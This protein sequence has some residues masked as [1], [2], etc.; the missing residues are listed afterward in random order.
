[1]PVNRLK[2]ALGDG[3]TQIG[4]WSSLSSHI[5]AEIVAGAGFDWILIDTE[6]SPNEV[7]D[8]HRQLQAIQGSATSVVVRPPW[9][10]P[11]VIKRLLDVGVQ[12]LLVPFVQNADEARRAVAATRYPPGGIRGVATTTRANR[13]GRVQDYLGRA[14]DEICVIV[15]IETRAALAGLEAIAAVEGVDA[16]FIGPSDLAA[17]MGHL[18]NNGHPEV[19]AAMD[20]AIARIRATGK[21]AGILTPVEADARRWLDLGCNLMAV[22]SDAGILARQADAL[23]SKFKCTSAGART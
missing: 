23:A 12:N 22:G 3:Q 11:V 15:Q 21:A 14:H 8:V 9:N 2:R 6:H 4:L 17:D 1:M 5:A 18:G 7:G 19:R 13:Y 20:D 16:L 10:E